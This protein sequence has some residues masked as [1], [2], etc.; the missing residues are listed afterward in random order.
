[1]KKGFEPPVALETS[2]RNFQAWLNH[3]QVVDAATGAP[4][5]VKDKVIT[6]IAGGEYGTHGYIDAY[7]VK[8]GEPYGIKCSSRSKNTGGMCGGSPVDARGKVS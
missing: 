6:G 4:L 1:M 5:V 8:T 3:G 2:P 7:D